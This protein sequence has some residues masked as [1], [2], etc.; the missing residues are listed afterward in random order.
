MPLFFDG[1]KNRTYY[2]KRPLLEI[3]HRP[4][5]LSRYEASKL[6]NALWGSKTNRSDSLMRSKPAERILFLRGHVHRQVPQM[7]VAVL[8]LTAVGW[9]SSSLGNESK[10]SFKTQQAHANYALNDTKTSFSGACCV[11]VSSFTYQKA[12]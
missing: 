12:S 6:S 7:N 9:A 3:N 8:T 11:Q 2:I 4:S 10:K 5:V 1:Q